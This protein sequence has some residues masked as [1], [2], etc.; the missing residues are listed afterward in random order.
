MAG[1]KPVGLYEDFIGLVTAAY[2]NPAA[3]L[4]ITFG[5]SV[6]VAI[7]LPVPIEVVLIA[8]ILEQRWGYLLSVILAM[9]TGKTVGAW[10]IF[11]LGLRVEGGIR[12]WADRYRWIDRFVRWCERFV[13]KTN[14][15]GLY[16][17]LSIP[18]MSD[19]VPLYLYALFNEEGKALDRRAFLISN[20]LAAWTRAGFLV[21]V[22]LTFDIFLVR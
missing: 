18:L 14:Y 13:R 8:P 15:I 6:L 21:L 17:L 2:N 4:S 3:Y 7:I 9:S 20:F 5:F 16:V 1:G 22:Y 19:T 11:Y 10:A 12:R